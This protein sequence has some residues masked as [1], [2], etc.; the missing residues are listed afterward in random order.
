MGPHKLHISAGKLSIPLRHRFKHASAERSHSES[1]I[2]EAARGGLSGIG[3]GCP[4]VYVTGETLSSACQ[5]LQDITPEVEKGITSFNDLTAWVA[6]NEALIDEHPAAWCALEIALLDLFA[7]ELDISL[8][9]LVGMANISPRFFRYTA[10]L[11]DDPLPVFRKNTVKYL[12]S[13]FTDFK[14]K[15]SGHDSDLEKIAAFRWLTRWFW[16]R[17]ITLRLDANN[18]W[19]D[20]SGAAFAHLSEFGFPLFGVEEPFRARAAAH[21]S[22]LSQALNTAIILDESLCRVGDLQLFDGLPGTWIGNIRISK[23]GGILRS[24]K[25]VDELRRRRW[26]IIVGAQ[27]GESSILTR[28]ALCVATAAGEYLVGQEGAFGT[29]LLSRD[30]VAPVLMFGW[31]GRLKWPPRGHLSSGL[32]ISVKNVAVKL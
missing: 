9:R 27:V 26:Q 20:N 6:A 22:A 2:V 29:W 16:R 3:E 23:M 21:M 5:W 12:A 7:K 19:D 28:A 15:I 18:L 25:M 1:L 32:G 30:P 24:L 10:V 31:A 17:A 13:G 14:I 8:E 11:G 4:R